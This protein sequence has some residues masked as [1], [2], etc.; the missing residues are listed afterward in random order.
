[1]SANFG[2]KAS[3]SIA[4]S[5]NLS[6]TRR[7]CTSILC[8]APLATN[9]DN[10]LIKAPLVA[11]T[12]TAP[13]AAGLF[14]EEKK[15]EGSEYESLA[16]YWRVYGAR[17]DVR[18]AP[19]S[20]KEEW[21]EVYYVKYGY[22]RWNPIHYWWISS[23]W[24]DSGLIQHWVEPDGRGFSALVRGDGKL[25]STPEPADEFLP[26][27]CQLTTLWS[28][29]RA[30][31]LDGFLVGISSNGFKYAPKLPNSPT[32]KPSLFIIFM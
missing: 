27:E 8:D 30:T 26:K 15:E 6:M 12:P 1:M 22:S 23:D 13:S 20:S 11:P 19:W 5:G 2:K 28:P 3:L 21:M 24:E 10:T 17:A 29:Y 18:P 7:P 4:S 25:L 16:D 9:S 32:P 31:T 14:L